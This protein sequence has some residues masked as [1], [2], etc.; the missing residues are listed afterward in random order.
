MKTETM[1]KELRSGDFLGAMTNSPY[2]L[3]EQDIKFKKCFFCFIDVLGY[4]AFLEQFKENAPKEIYQLLKNTYDFHSTSYESVT[5][6]IL[7][8]SLLIWTE[9]DLPIHFWNLINVV[10]LIREAF[11]K[12][13][14]SMRGGIS[15]GENFIEND[16]IV[17]PALVEAYELEQIADKP[18]IL[19][20]QEAK[21]LGFQGLEKVEHVFGLRVGT[22]F[23]L[24]NPEKI[25]IDFDGRLVLNP[26]NETNG[27]CFLR[28]GFPVHYAPGDASP[29]E[30]QKCIW[31]QDGQKDITTIREQIL[32][33]KPNDDSNNKVK[34]K[35]K[36]LVE[37]FN[38]WISRYRPH[39][40]GADISYTLDEIST[41]GMAIVEM[42]LGDLE[43][44][45]RLGAQLGYPFSVDEIAKRFDVVSKLPTHKLFVAKVG[46][47]VTGWVHV[48]I[49]S[50]SILSD[51]RAEISAL[52][53]DEKNRGKGV[54]RALMNAAEAWVISKNINLIRLRSNII[55]NDAHKFY[56]QLGYVIKKSWH[57]FVKSF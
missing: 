52:V 21:E 28:S 45:T 38:I 11:F 10:E 55:R 47:S 29:T 23:R 31:T 3:N 2:K 17:S 22:Y 33:L 41:N 4:R 12:R 14:L 39:S 13:N 6:K 43:Q 56:Q 42:K 1:P 51:T 37:K 34:L 5:I 50:P 46:S 25:E 7:S 48:N 18:R 19:I 57:L 8:D 54:G 40:N 36:Y 27:L 30:D 15:F 16:I 24:V 32:R 20:S 49:E 26:F 53:V 44:V 9:G 35:Y